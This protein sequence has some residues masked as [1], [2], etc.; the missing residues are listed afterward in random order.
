MAAVALA[1]QSNADDVL[2]R[3]MASKVNLEKVVKYALSDTVD[4][5]LLVEKMEMKRAFDNPRPYTVNSLFGKYPSSRGVGVI[6]AGI[7]AREFAGKGT[8][9]YKYLMPNIKGGKR[10]LKRSEKGLQAMGILPDGVM[11]IQGRNFARDS[12]GDIPGGQYTRMLAELGVVANGGAG[13]ASQ[14]GSK[15][16][17]KPRKNPNTQFFVMKRRKGDRP[18]AIAERRGKQINIMLVFQTEVPY[19]KRYDFYG[20]GKATILER[21]PKHFSRI[22]NRMN[23]KLS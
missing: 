8:P 5:L 4:D 21:Y 6:N 1:V 3:V 17:K 14:T 16:Q 10:R 22:F 11:T 23:S 15:G 18:F 2:R 9:A 12:Y 20:I 7:A 13:L 19:K